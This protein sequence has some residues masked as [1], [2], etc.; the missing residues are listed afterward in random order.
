MRGRLFTLDALRTLRG[1][2][3]LAV[4]AVSSSAFTGAAQ[5]GSDPVPVPSGETDT[6]LEP[7]DSTVH[8]GS[9]SERSAL[10]IRRIETHLGPSGAQD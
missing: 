4:G 3:G 6:P 9:V 5:S 10:S 7:T 8:P 1:A 2:L